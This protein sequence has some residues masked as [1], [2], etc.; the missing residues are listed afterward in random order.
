[1]KSIEH[2]SGR[3]LMFLSHVGGGG[4]ATNPY[5]INLEI[6]NIAPG[7]NSQLLKQILL[8]QTKQQCAANTLQC[9]SSLDWI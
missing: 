9:K 1:M 6:D 2:F 5:T 8:R 7:K 4:V 3:W